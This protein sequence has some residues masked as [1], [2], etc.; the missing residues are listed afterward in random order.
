MLNTRR[1]IRAL[2][3]YV[4]CLL[5]ALCVSAAVNAGYMSMF[6]CWSWSFLRLRQC[7]TFTLCVSSELLCSLAT[8]TSFSICFLISVPRLGVYYF[9]SLTLSVCVCVRLS[10]CLSV[11]TLLLFWSRWNRTISWPSVLRDKNYKTLFFDFWFRPPNEI[12][13]RCLG[14]PG[15][16]QG[17][18]IQWNHAKCCGV[19]PCCHGS[20]ISARRG[21]PVAYRL[22][23]SAVLR[24][25]PSRDW[26]NPA[27]R[28]WHF[29]AL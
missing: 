6:C 25:Q 18:P 17:W 10:V 21:D 13:R 8:E 7:A 27:I 19:D 24:S 28:W 29:M 15:G 1:W 16:F 4:C 23:I 12:D 3:I 26:S 14:L 2:M 20:E 9:L 11:T 22:V 5:P